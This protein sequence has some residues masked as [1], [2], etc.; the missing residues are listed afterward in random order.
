[1]SETSGRAHSKVKGPDDGLRM[2]VARELHKYVLNS[3]QSIA[4]E[5]FDQAIGSHTSSHDALRKHGRS[6]HTFCLR[7]C[8]KATDQHV[9]SSPQTAAT[10]CRNRPWQTQRRPQLCKAA[11]SGR[12]LHSS[13]MTGRS[14]TSGAPSSRFCC[15]RTTLLPRPKCACQRSIASHQPGVHPS[16]S[17]V[18]SCL[19]VLGTAMG[20]PVERFVFRCRATAGAAVPAIPSKAFFRPLSNMK[21][22]ALTF[23]PRR[24]VQ[25]FAALIVY[26][27][28]LL[29]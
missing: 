3:V 10:K 27:C 16:G 1:M 11:A 12:K 17:R 23:G 2:L 6:C 8:L 4:P 9:Q 7:A 13:T 25:G 5:R 26:C 22:F 21:L 19:A 24:I 15:A 18:C 14:L 29:L 20:P 28:C